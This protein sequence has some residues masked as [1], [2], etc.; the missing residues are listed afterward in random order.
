MKP[1]TP[2]LRES[3]LTVFFS[4][5]VLLLAI[6]CHGGGFLHWESS[7]FLLNYI[8]DRPLPAIIFDPLK[9]DWGLYQCRELSYFFD[10]LDAQIIYMILKS[11]V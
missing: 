2:A 3:L 7:A 1:M 9:N 10:Y 11:G 4:A 5:V 8:A 6:A